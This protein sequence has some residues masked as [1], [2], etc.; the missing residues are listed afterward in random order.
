MPLK[1]CVIPGDF[2]RRAGRSSAKAVG[3]LIMTISQCLLYI[4][5]AILAIW[6]VAH[7][8][9][10]KHVVSGFGDI[11]EDNRN[12]IAMEWIVEGVLLLF[13]GMLIALVTYVDAVH[14]VSSVVY[15]VSVVALLSLAA[16]AFFT[17]FKIKFLPFRMC[18]FVL[19]SCAV[20]IAA[21]GVF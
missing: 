13:M 10:T 21:G 15:G 4:G 3:V 8:V 5:A 11:G 16:V 14:P 19:L 2:H 12:I 6:G 18:P 9:P 17:G 1:V 20:V 7:L